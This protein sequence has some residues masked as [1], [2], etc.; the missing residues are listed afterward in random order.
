MALGHRVVD[1]DRG[2]PEA[3][4]LGHLVEPLDPGG[5]SV[6]D[7]P[8]PCRPGSPGGSLQSGPG[9][10]R[11]G[12]L[13][14]RW[15]RSRP[16]T[17]P[18]RP[19]PRCTSRVASPPSSRIMLAWPPWG[20]VEE[21]PVGVVPV[22]V[23]RLA[24]AGE[25]RECHRPRSRQP[26]GPG[27]RRCCRRPSAS[28]PRASRARSGP[29]SGCQW[30]EPAMRAAFRAARELFADRHEP[31]HLGLGDLD[32]LPT[33]V[34]EREVRHLVVGE[35]RKR[36]SAYLFAASRKNAAP[37]PVRAPVVFS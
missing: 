6:A 22:L 30:S 5:V 37:F 28:A 13:L 24:L 23:E 16:P 15:S 27:W 21:N 36:S 19:P 14:P 33:P 3:S 26:R 20:H 17:R 11:R 1:V 2:E 4:L 10:P 18:S 7:A 32:L 35:L 9:S 29:R 25:H 8:D 34:G 12:H 31:R